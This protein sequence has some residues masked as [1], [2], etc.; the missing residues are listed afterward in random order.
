MDHYPFIDVLR[1]RRSRRFGLG[2]KM[3]K[4]PLA[5]TSRHA[6]LPLT[7]GEEAALAFAAAGIS[8][9]ALA[10]L[11]F[12]PGEGG[13]VMTGL[14]GRTVA[15]GDGMQTVPIVVTND[16]ATYLVRR[17]REISPSEIP[18]LI[19]LAKK[20]EFTEIYRRTRVKVRDGRASA[21]LDPMFNI[22]VNRWSVHSPGTT[23][24]LPVNDLT[25]MYINGCLEIF[26]E[27]TGAFVVDE[28]AGFQ[29]AG[30]ASFAKS[31]GGHLHDD[32]SG[33]R[34]LTIDRLERLVEDVVAIEQGMVLQNLG[35]MAQALGLGGFPNFAAHEFG[36]FL[37]LGFNMATMPAGRYLSGRDVP[38]LE[39]PLPFPVGLD[40]VLK[41]YCPPNYPSMEAAVGAV[42]DTK[43]AYTRR[44]ATNAWKDGQGVS[45][46]I[47]AVSQAAIDATL[48]YCTHVYET[49]GRF[50]ATVAP[51]RTILGFQ[52][53]HLDLDFY[54]EHYRPD[55]L[56][57][58]ERR[59]AS[60]CRST[61]DGTAL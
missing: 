5:F 40:P 43:Y 28:R 31:R 24:F 8:G 4:G 57:E 11:T 27:G 38:G 17:P 14:V 45:S 15:S 61:V 13:N 22:L 30:L 48:A 60:Q 35:L 37:A 56:T 20:G 26:N 39:A 33:G 46:A 47:P 42:L 9:Y 12:A 54:E 51:Y 7:E 32:L 25:L 18:A 50:P 58:S 49:Y 2:M 34:V 6:P 16:T 59:H 53:C 19:D 3:E 36:W 29:P 52:A 21:P 23:Y 55:A 1:D 10:D 44:L 41:A